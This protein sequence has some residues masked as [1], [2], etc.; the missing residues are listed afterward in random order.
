MKLSKSTEKLLVE[1]VKNEDN[2]AGFLKDK[3]ESLT[4]SED[5][6]IRGMLKELSE[7]G[8]FQTTW[9]DN[10]P[11]N[12]SLTHLAEDYLEVHEL[13]VTE[14][15][16]DKLIEILRA[17]GQQNGITN[18]HI[19]DIRSCGLSQIGWKQTDE[20]EWKIKIE[21]SD[22]VKV[23][24]VTREI[25]T[26][27]LKYDFVKVDMYDDD[28]TPRFK[29][30]ID[31]AHK[32]I[33]KKNNTQEI[34]HTMDKEMY[35]LLI[36]GNENAWES[37]SVIFDLERC[38]VEY[39]DKDLIDKFIKLGKD[40]I[41][42]IKN[43]PCIFAYENYCKK[44]A[45]IGYITDIIVRKTGIKINFE[46]VEILPLD[47]LHKLEFELDIRDW[48][49]NRTHW[50]IKKVN[51]YKVLQ[52]ID[53][54]LHALKVNKLIDITNHFFDVSF[55]F[56]GESRDLVEQVLKELEKTIDRNQIFYDNYYISQL[57]RPSLDTL[58]QDI[59]KNRSK[60]IVIF[61]CEKYQDKEW[62]GIEF[63]P[64]REIIMEKEVAKIMYIRLDGGH[65]D[66][67]F[68]TDGYIDGTKFTPKELADFIIERLNLIV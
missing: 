26:E 27:L 1:M 16:K 45:S 17:I 37:N 35:N 41:N 11:Y 47:S 6:K 50:A 13:S 42:E 24:K 53:I 55:T 10:I 25:E 63:K 52:S 48:E 67:V 44:N 29:R 66:G 39:T 2:L 58:L 31:F 23:K 40:E 57:A 60:L 46:K 8:L 54:S 62:C 33:I 38:I 59:Y 20:Q 32:S 18:V 12:P 3:F 61:L 65:V 22:T 28:S 43:F 68:K 19:Y 21:A 14:F 49:L 30:Y 5:M 9:A 15:D 64:I 56:A 51:L 7:N 36:S 34:I 4:G